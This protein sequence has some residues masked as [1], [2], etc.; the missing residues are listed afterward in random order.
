MALLACSIPPKACEVR[1]TAHGSGPPG[2]ASGIKKA[3]GDRTAG[4]R[5][6]ITA[7]RRRAFVE[8]LSGS[9][10]QDRACDFDLTE[11]HAH[12]KRWAPCMRYRT[13]RSSK[14]RPSE[15]RPERGE[16]SEPPL[17]AV[18][19]SKELQQKS[20][21]EKELLAGPLSLI[22]RKCSGPLSLIQR[23]CSGSRCCTQKEGSQASDASDLI[24]SRSDQLR[25]AESWQSK[26]Q[27]SPTGHLH[28]RQLRERRT[29]LRE[30][31]P[32][33]YRSWLSFKTAGTTDTLL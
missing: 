15:A 22:Q 26:T 9:C 19:A 28:G 33:A 3:F 16:N 21:Q 24:Q 30:V 10:T 18:K 14:A 20:K 27:P 8:T 5:V 4:N 31:G 2:P 12:R 7:G 17:V 11:L 6:S 1:L 13:E 25:Q 23:K 29:D 32:V